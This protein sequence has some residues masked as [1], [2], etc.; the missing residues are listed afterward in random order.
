MAENCLPSRINELSVNS[1][2]SCPSHHEY[3]LVHKSS[4]TS[5]FRSNERGIKIFTDLNYLSTIQAQSLLRLELKVSGSLTSGCSQR[6]A[7]R[8][9]TYQDLPAL[10]FEWV[11]GVTVDQWIRSEPAKDV[12]LSTRLQVSMSITKAV[13]DFHEAGIFHGNLELKNVV[14][15]SNSGPENFH[16]TLIDYSRSIILADCFYSIRDENERKAYVM[17]VRQKDLND[18]GVILYSVLSNHITNPE[19][20]IASAEGDADSH[21]NKR[22]KSQLLQPANNMPLYLMSLVSSL[23]TPVAKYGGNDKM[24]YKNPRDVLTDLQLAISKPDIYLKAHR[25]ADLVT[26]PLVLPQDSFYGRRAEVSMLQHSFDT[27]MEGNSKSCAVVVSGY[28][29]AG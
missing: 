24:Q 13:C 22:G 23:L 7:L 14:I 28:A 3:Q 4:M 18:L 29:G 27:M 16:A 11:D 17:S 5:I 8:V 1:S 20:N 15:D 26:K 6:K 2:G 21:Q 25:W 19:R 10:F 12:T 9:D